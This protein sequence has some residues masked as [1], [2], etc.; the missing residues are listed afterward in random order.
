MSECVSKQA[1]GGCPHSVIVSG[2]RPTAVIPA[3]AADEVIAADIVATDPSFGCDPTGREDS[4]RALQAALDACRENGGGVVFLPAGTYRITDRVTLPRGVVLQGDWQDPDTVPAGEAPLYGTVILADSAPVSTDAPRDAGVLFYV[5]ENAGIVGLTVYYPRQ[6]TADVIPYGFAFYIGSSATATLRNVTVLNAYRA[7]AVCALA[8][9]HD[10]AKLEHLRL[11]ALETGLEMHRSADVGYIFDVRLSP[12]YWAGAG[13]GYAAADPQGLRAYC[14]AYLTGMILGDLDAD[15]FS[16]ITLKGCRTGILFK[17]LRREGFW[18]EFYD[19]N[20]LDCDYG[21]DVRQISS[22]NPPLI[23]RG[24]IE[25]AVMAVRMPFR[26]IPLHFCDVQLVGETTGRLIIEEEDLSAFPLVH[27]THRKPADRL[28]P[29]PVA[30]FSKT[31]TDISAALQAT[32]D[33]AAATG[34]VVRLPAG[35]FTLDQPV[36][37]PCGVQLAGAL[38]IVTRD[39]R[40]D[41]DNG[42]VLISYVDDGAAVTLEENAGVTGLRMWFP[43]YDTLTA[44]EMLTADDPVTRTQAAI[45]GAGRGVFVCEVTVNGGFTAVDV[46]GCDGHLVRSVYGCAYAALVRCGGRDGCVE[47][48][49]ANPDFLNRRAIDRYF[50]HMDDRT[51]ARWDHLLVPTE[52]DGKKKYEIGHVGFDFM[53]R[54]ILDEYCNAFYITD[55]Q[56]QR[57]HNCFMYT[58]HVLVRCDDSSDVLLLNNTV[59]VLIKNY[60]MF[61]I[62][63]STARAVNALRIFG[64]SVHNEDSVFDINCRNDRRDSWEGAYHSAVSVEDTEKVI[65]P[66]AF[67]PLNDCDTN[68]GVSGPARLTH[69]PQYVKEGSGALCCTLDSRDFPVALIWEFP[70][71][72]IS[73]LEI[74]GYLHMWIYCSDAAGVKGGQVE[75]CSGGTHDVEELHWTLADAIRENGWNEAYFPLDNA[76]VTGGEI[77]STCVNYLRIYATEAHATLAVDDIYICR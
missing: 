46:R 53:C 42:T 36:R 48:C 37:V 72:D 25:G 76:G 45:R 41:G 24:R 77:D 26:R 49:L 75:L 13:C 7:V 28:Y 32:L 58:P 69:D 31:G 23:S 17:A 18:G 3:F 66:T 55:A 63:R 43:R 2:E 52:R 67:I 54:E 56:G 51:R 38:P 15:T 21:I 73:S 27:G 4:T 40:G 33:S 44:H 47:E 12:E 64:R 10:M 29:V 62:R 74:G 22:G 6:D 57:L 5:P 1:C 35:I 60:P 71:R 50:F 70:A 11:T 59:D 30:A 16:E 61:D 9:W 39:T 34:G 19:I 68:E 14:R 65:A 20:I 8:E